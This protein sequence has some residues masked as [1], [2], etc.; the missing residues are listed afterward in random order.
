MY[1]TPERMILL[2]TEPVFSLSNL[3]N[4]LRNERVPDGVPVDLWLDQ[5]ALILAT[6]L[7]S[8]CNVV[9]IMMDESSVGTSHQRIL[10]LLQKAEAFMLAM[11]AASRNHAGSDGQGISTQPGAQPEQPLRC[12]LGDGCADIG[13]WRKFQ[14]T[15]KGAYYRILTGVLVFITIVL[16]SNSV[17]VPKFGPNYYKQSAEE[18]AQVAKF[19]ALQ[20]FG[21]IHM[22]S[23]FS[24]FEEAF[25][26]VEPKEATKLIPGADGQ[27]QLNAQEIEPQ[28]A[29]NLNFVILPLDNLLAS[30][31]SRPQSDRD[32]N[33]ASA[34]RPLFVTE[35]FSSLSESLLGQTILAPSATTLSKQRSLQDP[36]SSLINSQERWSV[37]VNGLRNKILS[38]S[39]RPQGGP[40]LG[41]RNKPGMVSER[42]WYEG[43]QGG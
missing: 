41:P 4:A 36:F 6:F 3:E 16:I 17:P 19:S 34:S 24:R 14:F 8:V 5:Q 33:D 43:S 22:A 23:I 28:S 35:K 11:S 37:W 40:A 27:P 39:M 38:I 20:M 1:V 2:D 30:H 7:L 13:M 9:L 26:S 31:S 29:K 32:D 15:A 25:V 12:T 18:I 21:S 10:K 42:E